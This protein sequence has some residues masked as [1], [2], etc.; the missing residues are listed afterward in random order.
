MKNAKGDIGSLPGA[1][2]HGNMAPEDCL[3]TYLLTTSIAY[4]LLYIRQAK[5]QDHSE[6]WGKLMIWGI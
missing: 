4:P 6:N 1:R 5:A 2:G 3:I